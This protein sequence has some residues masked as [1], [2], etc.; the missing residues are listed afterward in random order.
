M[1]EKVRISKFATQD[2]GRR[3]QDQVAMKAAYVISDV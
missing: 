3:T 2:A 1:L